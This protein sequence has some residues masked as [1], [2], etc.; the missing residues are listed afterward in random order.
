MAVTSL[1]PPDDVRSS[2]GH[3]QTPALS[4]RR[5]IESSVHT[6]QKYTHKS[7]YQNKKHVVS[8]GT[9]GSLYLAAARLNSPAPTQKTRKRPTGP[10]T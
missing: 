3:Q 7:L 8:P 9:M 2:E 6:T 4:T 10:K 5:S 1:Q